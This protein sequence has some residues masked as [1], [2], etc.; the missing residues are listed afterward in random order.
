LA[1]L[2]SIPIGDRYDLPDLSAARQRS[3]TMDHLVRFVAGIAEAGPTLLVV[4]DLH[5]ADTS[6]VELVESL[7]NAA[8]DVPLLGV[9]R[10][11]GVQF[12][13]ARRGE[14]AGAGDSAPGSRAPG[15]VRSGL[16]RRRRA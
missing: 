4:E 9:C 5:W 6:T 15:A 8:P 10:P 16:A 1:T 7:V 14:R 3:L 13:A 11:A 12:P 2:L